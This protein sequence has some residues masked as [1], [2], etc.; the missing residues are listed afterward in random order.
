MFEPILAH[1]IG[2]TPVSGPNSPVKR[3]SDRSKGRQVDC[4]LEPDA[5][6]FKLRVTI[7]A[8]GQGRWGEEIDYPED[9][10][11]SGFNPVL[12]VLDPTPN[13]KLAELQAAFER[14]GGQVYIGAEAW[15]HLD[16]RAGPTMASFIERYV[17]RPLDELVH[18]APTLDGSGYLPEFTA[19]HDADGIT[20]SI[21]GREMRIVRPGGKSDEDDTN[22]GHDEAPAEFDEGP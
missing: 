8:S 21:G 16:D 15:R 5:Y 17:R 20:I 6:E 19:R 13:P 3:V 1:S 11:A 2:G 22:A 9:C 12:V 14:H 4:L 10:R 18:A 7:A